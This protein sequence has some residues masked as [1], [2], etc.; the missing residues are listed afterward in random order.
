MKILFILPYDNTYKYKGG[1]TRAISYAP[2]TLSVL[3]AL[4]PKELG[5]QI[6]TID[7]GIQKPLTDE[8]F[9]IV[10]I[11]CVTSSAK[12]AYELC[13]FWKQK[14]SYVILGGVH[15]TLMTKEAAA[16]S[17][18]VFVGFAEETLQEFFEDY[19]KGRPKKIY[20]N[21]SKCRYLSMPFPRRDLVSDK[22][23]KIPTVI[24]NRGCQNRCSYCSVHKLWGNTG[25]TRPVSEVISE[26]QALKSKRIIL[27]DPSPTSDEEYAEEFFKALI[28]LN[29]KWSGLSTIDVVK[30]N[31]LFELMIR[32]GCEGI[33]C[34]FES[35]QGESLKAVSKSTNNIAE[36]KYAVDEF[37]KADIPVLGCFVAGFDSD[38]KESLLNTID[39]IDHIGIDLPRFSILTPFPGTAMFEEYEKNGR[40]LTMDWNMY[41][42]MHV[43]FKHKKMQTQELYEAFSQMWKKAYSVKRIIRR[44][45]NTRREKIIK[46]G[47]NLGFKYYAHKLRTIDNQ[48]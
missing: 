3:A 47:A 12:R 25:L 11:T 34:G 41:D 37:H 45:K 9:D 31:R 4:V 10:A 8:A 7:E 36:Y 24:A 43:V 5:A 17:D 48:M 16:H 42:T 20:R 27:L 14:G 22:Y 19:I 28:P 26:I 44:L 18:S 6:K 13:H 38:T 30:K 2:L 32:S 1:F 33:L 21:E 46:L 29:I 23:M 35:V 39:F 40:I 15:P